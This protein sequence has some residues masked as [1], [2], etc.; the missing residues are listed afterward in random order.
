VWNRKEGRL[1]VTAPNKQTVSEPLTDFQ[2]GEFL[3]IFLAVS[4]IKGMNSIAAIAKQKLVI[5]SSKHYDMIFREK[6]SVGLGGVLTQAL[7]ENQIMQAHDAIC[8]SQGK[9]EQNIPWLSLM[10]AKLKQNIPGTKKKQN[11]EYPSHKVPTFMALTEE[12]WLWK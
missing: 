10:D 1:S 11:G 4:Q 5:W 8:E 7:I 3:R 2:A 9:E 6:H 12:K